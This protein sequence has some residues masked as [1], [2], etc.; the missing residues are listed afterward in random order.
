M[1]KRLKKVQMID[2]TDLEKFIH[3][4]NNIDSDDWINFGN[5]YDVKYVFEI[6]EDEIGYYDWSE[7]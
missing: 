4:K 5:I 2:S 6:S 1:K 7:I 3:Y